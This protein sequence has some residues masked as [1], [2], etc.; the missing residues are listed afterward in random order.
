M[1]VKLTLARSCSAPPFDAHGPLHLTQNSSKLSVSCPALNDLGPG[2]TV[3]FS[4]FLCLL[5][6]MLYFK[7]PNTDT[8]ILFSL[9]ASSTMLVFNSPRLYFH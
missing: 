8:Y 4:L 5:E 3:T 7:H 1:F 2:Q 9:K 6:T